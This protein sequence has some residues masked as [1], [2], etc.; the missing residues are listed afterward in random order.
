MILLLLLGLALAEEPPPP[1]EEVYEIT[2]YGGPLVEQARRRLVQELGAEGYTDV[3]RQEDHLRLRNE[4][5][6]KGEILL[7]DDGWVRVKRQ[8]VQVLAPEMPGIR[9]NS[10]VAWAA[11]VVYPPRCVRVG[12][13]TVGRRKF[14]AQKGR[15]LARIDQDV[16]TYGDRVA[17]RHL[18]GTLAELP[19]RLEALWTE[20]VPLRGEAPVETPEDRRAALL[21]YWESRTDTLWGDQVRITVEA[22]LR[23]VVQEGPHAF[24]EEEVEA[25]NAQRRCERSLD[26]WGSWEE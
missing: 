10:P 25:F 26:L 2:V 12:G 22:F 8:P 23:S 5:A 9:E 24:T 1:D 20:G 7:Y 3:E 4:A 11:C 18:E 13:A 14:Q 19:D 21:D 16:Q 6:W 17:D 15:T